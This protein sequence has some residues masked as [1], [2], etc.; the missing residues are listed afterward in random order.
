VVEQVGTQEYT[1]S[2]SA[3][4]ARCRLTYGDEAVA[5]SEPHLQT[6]RP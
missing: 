2:R 3:F 6:I 5:D 4:L 1:L